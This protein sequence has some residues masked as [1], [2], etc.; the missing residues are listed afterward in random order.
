[1]IQG[2]VFRLFRQDL[3]RL[4]EEFCII[5]NVF[6]VSD[7]HHT[8]MRWR[9]SGTCEILLCD[10]NRTVEGLCH[11]LACVRSAVFMS[12]HIG[13]GNSVVWVVDQPDQKEHFAHDFIHLCQR[14]RLFDVEYQA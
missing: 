14:L 9:D 6:K 10:I 4:Y 3:V 2:D 12:A 5:R 8:R 13:Q 11:G 7:Q 1:M